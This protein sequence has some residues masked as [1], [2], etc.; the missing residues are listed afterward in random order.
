MNWKFCY[1]NPQLSNKLS[2]ELNIHPYVIRVLLNRGFHSQE[3]IDKFLNPRLSQIYDPFL[4]KDMDKAV[5]RTIKAIKKSEKI[6]IYGD[7]DVDGITSTT[8]LFKTLKILGASPSFY[9]PHRIDEGYGLT[10]NALESVLEKRFDLIITVDCGI[11]SVEEVNFL[12]NKNIDVIIT[13]HHLPDDIL[14]GAY[15]I[16][17]PNNPDEDYPFKQLAGVGVVFK[18]CHALLKKAN[19]PEDQAKIFLLSHLDLVAIGTIADIVPLIDENRIL[20]KN[21]LMRISE[22]KN[23]GLN[24]MLKVLS[25]ND[26]IIDTFSVGY[27]IAPRLNAAGRT[28]HSKICVEFLLTEEPIKGRKLSLILDNFNKDRKLIEDSIMKEAI[29]KIECERL[30]KKNKIIVIFKEDW[31]LGVIGIVASKLVDIYKRPV[32]ILQ[33]AKQRM[34]GSARSINSFNILSAIHH[35]KDTLIKY[36]GHKSAAGLTLECKDLERF[37]TLINEYA[38]ANLSNEDLLESLQIDCEIPFSAI[39]EKLV[40]DLNLLEPFGTG[41]PKPVFAS[42]NISIVS[43]PKLL[44]DKHIKMILKQGNFTFS[45]IGFSMPEKFDEI[46]RS[47]IIKIA[48]TPKF[49]YYNGRE[50]IQLILKDLMIDN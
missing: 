46:N 7:Y 25:L 14:P 31:H 41:N 50:S 5:E 6:L 36:G 49:D 9:I 23:V 17:N 42:N 12:K 15:A 38:E 43:E 48:F 44:K 35:C 37:Y 20:V 22:T 16:L 8:I 47:Q 39:N 29:E 45:A 1:P 26:K 34:K 28:S 40:E 33:K 11:S 32:I 19:F 18:F 30:H 21:G 27:I 13:D 10:M 24:E 4:M 3:T 2:S